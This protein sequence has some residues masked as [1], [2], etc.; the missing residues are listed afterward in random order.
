MRVVDS[1]TEGEPTRVIVSGGP[2]L[3][4]GP[5]V[6]RRRRFAERPRGA[7]AGCVPGRRL[8]GRREAATAKGERCESSFYLYI[9]R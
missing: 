7:G 1:H 9:Y 3:G 6:E 4:T 5:L 8:F 2:D